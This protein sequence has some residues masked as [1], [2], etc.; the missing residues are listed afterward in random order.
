MPSLIDIRRRIRSVRNTQQITKAMK[1]VSAAKLR[2]AQERVIAARPYAALL[3]KTLGNV[4][5]AA[6]ADERVAGNPLL[7]VR[8]ESRVQ[9]VLLTAD[10]GLAGAFNS[11]LIKESQR[12]ILERTITVELEL[13]G[14]KGRDFWRKQSDISITGEHIGLTAK[15]D[16]EQAA[17]I[18]RKLM[19]RFA[20]AE[21]DA[22]YLLCNEFKSVMSQKLTMKRVLPVEMPAQAEQVDYIFEQPPLQMLERLLPRYVEIEIYGALL[23]SAAAEQAARMTAME[24][25]TTNAAEMIENLTLYMNRVRQASITR[26]IIEVVSGAA[27]AE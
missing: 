23:E 4:A 15:P 25:A 24:S 1:M 12:F 2:R 6:G 18:A 19:E 7:A 5:A 20:N 22:V 21:I 9:L 27:A 13:L 8:P 10:K 17:A 3:R 14:R 16:Y 11:N 26:E